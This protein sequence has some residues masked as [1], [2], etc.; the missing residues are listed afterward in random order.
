MLT[1]LSPSVS[2]AKSNIDPFG[3]ALCGFGSPHT[4]YREPK[5]VTGAFIRSR[6]KVLEK[7]ERKNVHFLSLRIGGVYV[8]NFLLLSSCG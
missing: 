1:R 3:K 7:P 2:H 5:K 6:N 4:F 8:F